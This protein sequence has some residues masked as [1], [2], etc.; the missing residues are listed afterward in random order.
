MQQLS[1][2]HLHRS[3]TNKMLSG[4]C[5][6]LAETLGTDANLL[7]LVV[8]LLF[9]PF[10]VLMGSLYLVLTLLLPREAMEAPTI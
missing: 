9:V 1:R 5:G 10:S 4:V 3:T 8:L 7:R 6:G 2:G